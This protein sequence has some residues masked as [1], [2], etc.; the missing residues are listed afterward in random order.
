MSGRIPSR[1]KVGLKM[2]ARDDVQVTNPFDPY[3]GLVRMSWNKMNVYNLYKRTRTEDVS[4]KT[5]FQ[6]K[7]A[8]KKELRGY[9]VPNISETQLLNRHWKNQ[10]PLRHLTAKEK[11]R[12][13]PVQALSFGEL[14]RRLD[15]ILFR[16]HFASSIDMARS[17]VVMGHV[18]VNG[19]VCRF[20]SRSLNPGDMVTIN[21]K[22]IPTLIPPSQKATKAEEETSEEKVEA[23]EEAAKEE[24]SVKVA[25]EESSAK[26]AKE[27]T[28]ATED[29]KETVEGE[30][31]TP[32]VTTTAS[33]DSTDS[34]VTKFKSASESQKEK[35]TKENP[36]ALP[37][38][39]IPWMAP[40]MFVPEYLE[41]CYLTTS[42]VYLRSPLPQPDRVE[43][44]SPMPPDVH[45]L[46]YEWYSSI[47]R[48]KTK[49]PPPNRPLVI[50]GRSVLLKPKFDS[51]VRRQQH[52]D[53]DAK[54][55]VKFGKTSKASADTT[56]EAGN[57]A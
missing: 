52:T 22:V 53:R 31:K 23:K 32:E 8:A 49:R 29:A 14:E 41:V 46:A 38:N 1:W 33:S 12:L 5:V 24:K 45:A 35:D 2:H 43:I 55:A 40:F 3:K 15:V 44:P 56:S 19:D 20:P 28:T 47:K 11:E 7:W 54:K 25:A 18:K 21:P 50:N 17:Q 10:I 57:S 30:A 48:N 9:H 39:Y 27:A 36:G 13:P 34:P 37:F 51:I 42:V 6:Q 16:A 26:D 4:R